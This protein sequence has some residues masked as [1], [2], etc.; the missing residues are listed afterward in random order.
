MFE[1][2]D[3]TSLLAH[4][5]Y[6]AIFI[7]CLLE[8]E[9]ILILGGLAAHQTSLRLV[10]V[11]AVATLGGM[12]GDQILFWIGRS[13]G[14]RL[15]PRLHRKQAAIDRVSDLIKRYPTASIFSVRFLYGMRLVGPLV[16]GASRL[17]PFRFAVINLLGAGVWATLFVMAGYWAGQAL[18]HLLG[19]LKPYRLPIILGVVVIA[20]GVALYRHHRAKARIGGTPKP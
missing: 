1:H 18:E 9:T 10:D 12:I 5:G 3:I 13:F 16:I 8:G 7:G 15:L 4:Y 19:N 17:S 2:L 6:W 14:P 20:A 11:I